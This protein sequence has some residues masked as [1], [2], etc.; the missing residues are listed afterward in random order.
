MGALPASIVVPCYDRSALVWSIVHLGV[1]GFHR[2]H[3]ALYIEELCAS[4]NTEWGIVGAGVL[5]QD[6]GIQQALSKQDHLYTLVTRN[7][8]GTN[9]RVIGSI[10]DFILHTEQP[11]SLAAQ[12]ASPQTQ[13][14]SLTVTEGGYPVE[15]TTGE[16]HPD[17]M[18]A[19]PDSAFGILASGLQQRRQSGLAGLTV[20]SCDNVVANGKIA[21]RST[22]G[23]AALIDPELVT[24]IETNVTFPNSMV[25]RITPRTTPQDRQWL[26]DMYGVA[27]ECPVFTEPFRQW[28][29]EDD[30]ATKRIPL[31]E[32]D[33]IIASDVAPYE[34]MKLRLLNAGHSCLAYMAALVSIETVHDALADNSLRRFLISFLNTEA[35]PTVP[36]PV[37]VDLE[38]YVT[39]LIERFSNPA[40][41]DQISRLCLDGTAKF[42]K[43]LIPTIR[44]QLA[45]LGNF[46]LSAFALACWCE[47]LNGVDES[48]SRIDHSPDPGLAKAIHWAN[49]SIENPAAFLDFEEVFGHDLR[50]SELFASTFCDALSELRRNG[51]RSTIETKLRQG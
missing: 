31:E 29:I 21:R 33:I 26:G 22:L 7:Q 25:D 30:F 9:A 3:L 13:I 45:A 14:V 47:Y 8:A 39:S 27:D 16:Y 50:E 42:P 5:S 6:V 17:S 2:S 23:E 49:K 34:E 46:H 40:I 32:L 24:W 44:D 15:E 28:V 51:V 48:G 11:G 18:V 19:G 12:I 43:F 4:G 37:G 10:V 35:L 1:G 36:A 20:L 41:A 38:H